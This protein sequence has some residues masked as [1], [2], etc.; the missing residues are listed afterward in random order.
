MKTALITLLCC[1]PFFSK[2]QTAADVFDKKTS[3]TFTWLGIDY[4]HVKIAESLTLFNGDKPRTA[5]DIKNSYFK[6]WNELIVNEREKYSIEEMLN[7][8]YVAYDINMMTRI[9]DSA[10]SEE[11]VSPTPPVF[12]PEQIQ[13]FVQ[14]YPLENKSGIGIVFIA[15]SMNKRLEEAYYHIAI[16][17]MQTKEV[18]IQQR[19]KGKP[20][21]AGIRNYWAGSYRSAMATVHDDYYNKWR[22]KYA[23]KTAPVKPA[24]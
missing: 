23:A 22:A 18:L 21:G 6:S 15:E 9:N 10:R 3:Y 17:N 20:F 7:I 4:S 8:S 13:S 19:L 12:S 16:I 5:E 2:A 14:E 1:M 24:W 11:L